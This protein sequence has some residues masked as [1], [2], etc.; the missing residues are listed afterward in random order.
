MAVELAPQAPDGELDLI[1]GGVLV[2]PHELDQPVAGEQLARVAHEHR[3]QPELERRQ[4]K[5]VVA[6]AGDALHVVDGQRRVG[7]D[8]DLVVVGARAPLTAQQRLDAR[9]ELVAPERLRDEVVGARAQPA[10]LVQLAAAGRQHEDGHVGELAHALEHLPAVE[11]G[12]ADV[13]D[14][15]VGALGEQ[16]SQRLVAVGRAAHAVAG[17]FQEDRHE[18][19]D[20]LIVFDDQDCCG[21]HRAQTYGAGARSW[22]KSRVAATVVVGPSAG[23]ARRLMKARVPAPLARYRRGEGGG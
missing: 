5:L 16:H 9:H 11:A 22:A 20:H 12:Q 19:A 6:D 2:A 3:E 7:V 1:G 14:D 4:P 23:P 15:E 8:V 18:P 21:C 17:P 13:Q 10:H